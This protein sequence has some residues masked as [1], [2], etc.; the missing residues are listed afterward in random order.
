M[1]PGQDVGAE[2]PWD[3]KLDG[4]RRRPTTAEQAVPWLIGLVLALAGM[5]IVS[6][7]LIFSSTD[8][9]VPPF[10]PPPPEPT[11]A[12]TPAPRPPP[13]PEPSPTITPEPTPEPAP[14]P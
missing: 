11:L 6:L 12:L 1:G 13:S 8:G 2:P 7:A 10:A 4:N 9:F 5:L 14:T 3:T